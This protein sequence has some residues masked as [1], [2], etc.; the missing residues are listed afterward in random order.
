MT[1][2]TKRDIL[3]T[4]F[5]ALGD[6][7][8]TVGPIYDACRANP[9]RRFI[10]LTRS[11]PATLFINRPEN[12]TVHPVDTADYPGPRGLM[13]LR[14]ELDALYD[15][16][17]VADLHDVLRTRLLRSLFRLT[18][19]PTYHIDK[20]R[21][22]RRRLTRP[23]HK[24]LVQL[25]PMRD[26]YAETLARATG[27]RAP[28]RFTSI[29]PE[30]PD[31]ALFAGATG[32][33]QP[34]QRWIAIAPFAAHAGKV[35][36]EDLMGETVR[37]LAQLPD[38]RIFIFGF[39]DKESETIET[40]RK[41]NPGADIV[42]MAARKIGLPAELALLAHCDTMLSMDSAN[43]HLAGLAGLHTVSIWGA[44]HPFCGFRGA[45]QKDSDILQL[46]M[47]C[48]PCSVFGNKPCLRKDLHCL[49][50]IS[51]ARVAAAVAA[52]SSSPTPGAGRAD[53]TDR[54][55]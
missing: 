27:K 5:S 29:F 45:C 18:G 30:P 12:L 2:A 51:P 16:G 54:K 33:K 10:L 25:T 37:L 8:M 48:R 21:A 17:A 6:V 50:G 20:R 22:E 39:G 35:Y 9:D 52:A 44:T 14:R 38:T 36:P 55:S 42:N 15:I 7:A 34:G 4:R 11:H 49:R 28:G 31:P 23:R 47:T 26:R 1:Q 3:L 13:R 43:M 32:P 46:E 24:H 53:G 40:W 19:R 41:A